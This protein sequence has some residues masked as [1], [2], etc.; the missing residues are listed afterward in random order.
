MRDVITADTPCF[1][2]TLRILRSCFSGQG[3]NGTD[4]G[5]AHFPSKVQRTSCGTFLA[6]STTS[7][8][9]ASE[10]QPILFSSPAGAL[11]A[12]VCPSA[13]PMIHALLAPAAT[14]ANE[15]LPLSQPGPSLSCS[16][17]LGMLGSP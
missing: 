7:T 9:T 6:G 15:Y 17:T 8:T 16:H 10:P 12:N 3:S 11:N 2:V 13:T 1:V 4:F 14:R 5:S